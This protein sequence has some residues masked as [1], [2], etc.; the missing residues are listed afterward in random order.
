[1]ARTDAVVGGFSQGG[2]IALALAL[3]SSDKPRPAA[4]LA[5]SP[6]IPFDPAAVDWDA[7]GEVAVLLQH[8]TEEQKRGV[9]LPIELSFVVAHLFGGRFNV[10][11]IAI[12]C[13][14]FIKIGNQFCFEH[15]I[16]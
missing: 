14:R 13:S 4:V 10:F 9:G 12:K 2:G 11:Q 15:F 16:V 5:M 6:F 3:G 7:A 1:M 8:G